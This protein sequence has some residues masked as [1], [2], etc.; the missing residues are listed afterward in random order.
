MS[1]SLLALLILF[2]VFVYVAARHRCRDYVGRLVGAA[3]GAI[4]SPWG[5]VPGM[6]GLV[7]MLVH[8]APGFKL[9]VAFGMIPRGV[10]SGATSQ[11]VIESINGFVWTAIY[12][13]IEFAI[14]KI[15]NRRNRGTARQ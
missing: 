2:P 13:V 15:K 4:V 5:L 12:G 1:A 10:V 9:A 7:L 14:D 11:L 6:F 8:G 3:F